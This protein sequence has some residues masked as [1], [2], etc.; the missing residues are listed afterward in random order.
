MARGDNE[1]SNNWNS[2]ELLL[3]TQVKRQSSQLFLAAK[4]CDIDMLK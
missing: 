1:Y 4:Y 3:N 2:F